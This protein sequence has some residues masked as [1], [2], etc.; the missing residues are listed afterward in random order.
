MEFTH[1][2][3]PQV[4]GDP[5]FLH[6]ARAA[7]DV[8]WERGL[9]RKVGLC[10]GVAGN[11]YAFLAL[12]KAELITGEAVGSVHSSS[13]HPS[14]TTMDAPN[15][16]T[17]PPAAVSAAGLTRADAALHR[18]RQF[19][20]FLVEGPPGLLKGHSSAHNSPAAPLPHDGRTQHADSSATT[21]ALRLSIFSSTTAAAAAVQPPPSH[22]TSAVTVTEEGTH[23]PNPAAWQVLVHRGDMHGGDAPGSLF[24][25][26]AGVAWALLDV[27]DPDHAWFPG[28]ELPPIIGV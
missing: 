5:A 20:M 21:A 3:S 16:S 1:T 12:R 10:H 23:L 8:G 28:F 6:A 15:N 22:G 18:A 26:S 13:S 24:E 7:S 27:C 25:G 9:V 2:L 19:A 4:L 11:M 17:P 14:S